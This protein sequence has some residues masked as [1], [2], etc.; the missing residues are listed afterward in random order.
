MS[1]PVNTNTLKTTV[2]IIADDVHEL[3]ALNTENI[4]TQYEFLRQLITSQFNH[5]TKLILIAGVIFFGLYATIAFLFRQPTNTNLINQLQENNTSLKDISQSLINSK[6]LPK[7]TINK[8]LDVIAS[9][10]K[11]HGQAIEELRK[12]QQQINP[13]GLSL[14]RA[15]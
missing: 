11:F 8:T 5:S 1:S 15:C 3:N 9:E 13:E 14:L 2:D 7:E 6:Q 10:A 12:S 4:K